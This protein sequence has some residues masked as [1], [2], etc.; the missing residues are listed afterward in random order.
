MPD[1][2]SFSLKLHKS[3]KV[4]ARDGEVG[5]LDQFFFDDRQWR[6]RY[7]IVDTGGWLVHNQVLIPPSVIDRVE[8]VDHGYQVRLS[9]LRQQVEQSP[10]VDSDMPVSRQREVELFSYY[11]WPHDWTGAGVLGTAAFLP[12]IP[13]LDEEPIRLESAGDPHLRSSHEMLGYNVQA[14]DGDFGHVVDF[15]VSAEDWIIKNFILEVRKGWHFFRYPVPAQ[16]VRAV[17]WEDR[18]VTLSIGQ[19]E[20]RQIAPLSDERRQA[21]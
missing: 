2:K 11:R 13:A 8:R 5:R 19:S 20:I 9:L 15:D 10:D 17:S 18:S 6:V 3:S 16:S 21:G 14:A 12:T 7:L 4:F 1:S